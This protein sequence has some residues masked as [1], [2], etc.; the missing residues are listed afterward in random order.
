ML[1]GTKN[2]FTPLAQ[3]DGDGVSFV[4]IAF[5][6]EEIGKLR[7]VE[8]QRMIRALTRFVRNRILHPANVWLQRQR[9]Y[10]ELNALSDR[11]LAD[12]GMNRET[13]R[14]KVAATLPYRRE[15]TAAP[16]AAPAN[17]FLASDVAPV[18]SNEEDVEHAPLA[19]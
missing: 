18:A 15:E 16:A 10:E 5:L 19:A 11:S 4:D 8:T 14:T 6:N 1:H 12:L 9:L 2:G 7:A 13:L 3:A 17:T